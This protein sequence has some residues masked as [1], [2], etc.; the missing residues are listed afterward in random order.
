MRMP[1]ETLVLGFV[2]RPELTSTS[3][4]RMARFMRSR[5]RARDW[6]VSER[7]RSSRVPCASRG[8]VR[9]KPLSLSGMAADVSGQACGAAGAFCDGACGG[10]AVVGGRFVMVCFSGLA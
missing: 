8:T 1:C 9:E 5:L 7:N 3:P 6:S 2:H 10:V 4:S